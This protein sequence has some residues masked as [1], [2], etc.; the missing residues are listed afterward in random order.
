MRCASTT[1]ITSPA[2]V[3]SRMRS[4]AALKSCSPNS[5]T[6][7]LSST[8]RPVA[9]RPAHPRARAA[10]AP[11]G[12]ADSANALARSRS[13]SSVCWRTPASAGSTRP[14]NCIRPRRLSNTMT[15]SDTI[16]TISGVPSGSGGVLCRS[17]GST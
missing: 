10:A 2:R 6:K 9:G 11:S 13:R 4:T 5:E 8:G 17:L 15:S 16:S 1:C 7:W 12:A 14:I 3:Y